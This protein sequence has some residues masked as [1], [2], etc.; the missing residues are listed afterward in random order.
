VEGQLKT[1]LIVLVSAYW[2]RETLPT[3]TLGQKPMQ[4]RVEL[5]AKVL[6]LGW[7]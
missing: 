5:S 3:V 1:H 2:M 6:D 7:Q 4:V